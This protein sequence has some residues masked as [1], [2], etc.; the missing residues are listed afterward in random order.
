M[1]NRKIRTWEREEDRLRSLYL[2]IQISKWLKIF[3]DGLE[4]GRVKLM[5]KTGEPSHRWGTEKSSRFTGEILWGFVD[6]RVLDRQ[7]RVETG[8]GIQEKTPNPR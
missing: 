1:Q 7:T 2:K 3:L 4:G 5:K 6:W 8:K